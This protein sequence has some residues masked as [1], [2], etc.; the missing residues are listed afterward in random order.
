MS[1]KESEILSAMKTIVIYKSMSGFT[2]KYAEWISEELQADLVSLEKLDVTA[3]PGYDMVIFGGFLHAVGIMG[4]NVIKQ[5]IDKLAGKRIIIFATGASPAREEI[6]PEVLNHNFTPEQ[7]EKIKFFYLRGGFDYNKLNWVNKLLMTLMKWKIQGTKNPTP[8]EKG[9]L[10]AFDNP[11]DFTKKERVS[12][13]VEYA[14][15]V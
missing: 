14:K 4:V 1:K 6:I 7:Q 13:L 9:M 3:L 10:A 12:E 8:D 2:K 11:V 5:N 15:S